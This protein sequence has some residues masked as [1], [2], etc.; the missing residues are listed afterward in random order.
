[1]DGMVC[2]KRMLAFV[3]MVGSLRDD[4]KLLTK[5]RLV[6]FLT[7]PLQRCG[8]AG[9]RMWAVVQMYVSPELD[10]L[11]PGQGRIVAA[12]FM[13]GNSAFVDIPTAVGW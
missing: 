13:C 11:L 9:R 6:P 7:T 1:M 10:R 3:W 4:D 2:A 8:V 12:M 5:R